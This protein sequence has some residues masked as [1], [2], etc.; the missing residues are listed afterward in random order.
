[1]KRALV[2]GAAAALVWAC[3]ESVTA[4]GSC[5]DYCPSPDLTVKDTVIVDAITRDTSYRGYL[6]P[7]QAGSMQLVSLGEPNA[8]RAVIRFPKFGNILYDS[9]GAVG[10]VLETDS[11]RVS[12]TIQKRSAVAGMELVLH[13]LPVWVDSLTTLAETDPWFEDSTV[14]ATIAVPDSLVA[15][16]VSATVPSS[17]FTT[18]AEDSLVIAVGVALRA[19]APAFADFGTREAGVASTLTRFVQFDSSGVRVVRKDSLSAI[20]DTY[21]GLDEPLPP[22]DVF[23]VGGIPT[24]RSFLKV[25]LPTAFVS[26]SDVIRATLLLVPSEPVLGAPGDTIVVRADA[27]YADVGPKSPFIVP[28][29]DT[30]YGSFATVPVGSTDTIRIDVTS[31]MRLWR[32]SSAAPRAFMLRTVPEASSLGL[33]RVQSSR[34][35]GLAP[36]LRLTYQQLGGGG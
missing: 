9:L 16:S 6:T 20:L 21:L 2:L 35:P 27:I 23:E 14:V 10:P 24:A 30:S 11:F 22:P 8:T 34:V 5:P 36:G 4:P 13:R 1:M 12:L 7:D 18:Y 15:G 25:A 26:S 32:T 19:P 33:I 29:T 17:A 3:G 28:A 31:I